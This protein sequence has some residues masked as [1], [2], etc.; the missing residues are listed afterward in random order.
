[1]YMFFHHSSEEKKINVYFYAVML[2][3]IKEAA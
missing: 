2:E 3:K 1:M